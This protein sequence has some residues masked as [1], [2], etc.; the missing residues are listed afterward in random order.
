[1]LGDPLLVVGKLAVVFE[2]LSIRYVIGGSVA[3][4]M[5]GIPR[6]TQDV[7]V[8]AEIYGKHAKEFVARLSGE[9][10]VDADMVRDSLARR[11]SFNVLHLSTMFKADIFPT[12][13]DAWMESELSRGRLEDITHDG[14]TQT[15]R[16]ASPEDVLLHKLVWYRMGNEIS[17]RQWTDVLGILKIQTPLDQDYLRQWAADLKVSDL[18]ARALGAATGILKG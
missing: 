15:L 12:T 7:D 9:F 6:A 11:S 2:D 5:Y 1:V 16:C 8:A 17:E 13:R 3:S 10:Y 14:G 18:L 4:S